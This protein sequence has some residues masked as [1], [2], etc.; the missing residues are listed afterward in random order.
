MNRYSDKGFHMVSHHMK[1]SS[2]PILT[3]KWK[4]KPQHDTH[5]WNLKAKQNQVLARMWHNWDSILSW[6]WMA[7]LWEP[8]W[9]RALMLNLHTIVPTKA[10]PRCTLYRK[11]RVCSP[12][13][14]TRMTQQHY[15]CSQKLGMVTNSR[16]DRT[17]H[18]NKNKQTTPISSNL[19]DE[20]HRQN[21]GQGQTDTQ[22]YTLY[23]P[24]W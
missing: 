21:V 3:G 13:S 2:A 11:S 18:S 7:T 22:K 24:K 5:G 16:L 12:R 9:W 17:F 15:L 8:A 23:G 20:P 1:R 19:S 6:V 14:F 4:L 10:T